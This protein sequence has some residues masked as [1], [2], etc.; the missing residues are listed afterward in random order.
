MMADNKLQLFTT[1]V[2]EAY[3]VNTTRTHIQHD[4]QQK[5][6]D[7]NLFIAQKRE[8]RRD[9]HTYRTT[10]HRTTYNRLR[11]QARRRVKDIRRDRWDTYVPEVAL[12][13]D[14]LWRVTRQLRGHVEH[15]IVYESTETDEAITVVLEK[16]LKPNDEPQDHNFTKYVT[17]TV[18]D[19]LEGPNN[20]R[21]EVINL[22]EHTTTIKDLTSNKSPGHDYLTNEILKQMPWRE[23]VRT[24]IRY[25]NRK[26][27]LS[28]D[29]QSWRFCQSRDSESGN[30][31]TSFVNEYLFCSS[32]FATDR[33]SAIGSSF[34]ID[35][36]LSISQLLVYQLGKLTVQLVRKW[37]EYLDQRYFKKNPFKSRPVRELIALNKHPRMLQYR[38]TYHGH[39]D[40][41]VINEP[42]SLP[43]SDDPKLR[44]GEFILP[45]VAYQDAL[46]ISYEKFKDLQQLKKFCREE[47]RKFYSQ[48]PKMVQGEKSKNKYYKKNEMRR[49]SKAVQACE[50]NRL[51]RNYSGPMASLV[52]N[53]SFEK[54]P[55]QIM[56]P[57]A[58]P[59]DLQKHRR[60]SK[61]VQACEYNRLH[62]N[63]S[64][65]MASLVL[66]HSFEKL[67]DQIMYPYAEPY[68]LQKHVFSSCHF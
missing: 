5:Y 59:Y 15:G 18:W 43:P 50:Y 62:R 48:L 3:R 4:L 64:G 42:G 21:A 66:N 61:A 14:K 56:Y 19:Y 54:L 30:S 58:E 55:D 22:E 49:E 68:D 23:R 47:A 13:R 11:A 37:T 36:R 12:E 6:P 25:S 26:S 1:A 27:G 2:H 28:L 16:Q 52:L 35:L 44:Q 41:H 8:A 10:H 20:T 24:V 45:E 34:A 33:T 17:R 40:G 51:H 60:E 32:S 63:Y 65:P 9:W 29:E 67:P 57:Y 7:L 38:S 31:R 46:P 39:W 53:H